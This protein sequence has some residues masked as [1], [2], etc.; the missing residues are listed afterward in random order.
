MA[1]ASVALMRRDM[2]AGWRA[3]RRAGTGDGAAQT[4]MRESPGASD[5][6]GHEAWLWND[7]QSMYA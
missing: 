3:A 1:R 6:H 4:T 2:M 5:D 7:A